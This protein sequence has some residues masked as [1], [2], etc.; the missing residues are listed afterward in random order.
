[1]LDKKILDRTNRL[2]ENDSRKRQQ[3]L[4]KSVDRVLEEM[5][6]R[7]AVSSGAT[8]NRITEACADD[9]H[10]RATFIWDSLIR[11]HT[12]IGATITTTLR[13]NFKEDVLYQVEKA[14]R[15]I[16]QVMQKKIASAT[17]DKRHYDLAPE[18]QSVLD[19]AGIE[20]DLYVDQLEN[21]SSSDTHLE[22]TARKMVFISHA[23]DDKDIAGH[24]KELLESLLGK[25]VEVFLSS[26]P[27]AIDTGAEWFGED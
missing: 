10:E 12:A 1:M 2:I 7:N 5:A 15:E 22:G 26:H 21:T 18:M 25:S 19:T 24:V 4:H 16:E 11:A 27:A 23:V 14:A 3:S 8:I 9:L 13:E 6:G 17:P 20:I